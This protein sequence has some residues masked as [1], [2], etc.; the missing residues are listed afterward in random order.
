[1]RRHTPPLHPHPEKE[2]EVADDEEWK[3]QAPRHHQFNS[4]SSSSSSSSNLR[5][6]L[7]PRSKSS[8]PSTSASASNGISAPATSAQ[9]YRYTDVYSQSVRRYRGQPG[10]GGDVRN[11][12]DSLYFRR[13]LDHPVDAGDIDD[14]VSLVLESTS[15]TQNETETSQSATAAQKD[16][17]EWQ[18]MLASVLSGDVLRSEKTRIAVALDTSAERQNNPHINL[19]LGIRAKFHGRSEEEERKKLDERRLR[20]VDAII[21]E[22]MTFRVDS[23]EAHDSTSALKQVNAVLRR[24]DFAQS[25]YPTLKAFYVDKHAARDTAFQAR[26]DALNTWST[27]LT[28]LRNHLAFLRRWTGSDTLDI[29]QPSTTAEVLVNTS[30]A[31]HSF[32]SGPTEISDGTTFVERVLKEDSIQRTFEK[33]FLVTV[34]AFIGSARDAHVNLASL[35]REMNLPT[36]EQELVPLIS[37]PTRLVQASLKVRLDYVRKL[38]DPDILIIDQIIEDLKLNIGLAC[39]L[40][41]QYEVFLTPDLGGNWNLPQCISDD[42]DSTI[43]EALRIFFRLIHWKLR[44][45]TKGISFEIDVLEAD[46]PTF[47]DVSLTVAGGSSLVAEQLWY[48]T[49]FT[50]H[51]NSD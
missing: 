31:D 19:W 17:L 27:V 24:L 47:N 45:G 20:T 48:D 44:Y 46:W 39:T 11:D 43:F 51:S 38:Q 16:R 1:M 9:P 10:L 14:D 33:G 30:P 42:Y 36:F 50:I 21:E 3:V 13:G 28:A 5:T 37:F 12:P 2:P 6:R 22:I 23:D 8:F 4:P 40:K 41:R 25:F 15:N 32:N 29:T 7:K 26:C 49:S 35:F 18:N 34:H